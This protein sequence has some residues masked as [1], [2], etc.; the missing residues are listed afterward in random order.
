MNKLL[1]ISLLFFVGC[2]SPSPYESVTINLPGGIS[3]TE[4]LLLDNRDSSFVSFNS[5]TDSTVTS[6]DLDLGAFTV[7]SI[8]EQT[9]GFRQRCE[10]LITIAKHHAEE[11]VT[12]LKL[13][14]ERLRSQI[15]KLKT[16]DKLDIEHMKQS[17]TD[18]GTEW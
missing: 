13:E 11:R 9:D 6:L 2:S 18:F 14:S 16:R 5:R 1:L 17:L 3:C 15:E 7:P 8:S 4:R 10:E 12:H